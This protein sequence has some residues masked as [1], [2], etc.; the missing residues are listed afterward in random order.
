L[1]SDGSSPRAIEISRNKVVQRVGFQQATARL[2]KEK[3][4]YLKAIDITELVA[5]ALG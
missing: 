2:R 4:D 3:R 1:N 5:E